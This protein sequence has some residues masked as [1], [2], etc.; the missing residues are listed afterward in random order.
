MAID[1]KETTERKADRLG[2]LGFTR[3]P[4]EEDPRRDPQLLAAIAKVAPGTGLREAIDDVI[5]SHEGALIVV[6]D[7]SGLAFLYSGGIR[8]DAPFRP[9][10]LYELAKMDGAIIVDEAI[11]RLA[12]ANVQLMP[13]PTIPSNE[14]GTRHRTAERVAKQ[15]GALVVSAS[16]QRE[17]VTVFVGPAR[18]QLDPV[19][20]VLAKT[21]Q[22]LGTLETYRQRL[23]QVLTRLTALEFQNAV[24]LDDVLVVLQRAEM[25][26][27]MARRI[28]RDCVELGTE[29][30]LIRLQLEELVGDVPGE[31]DAVVR[32]YH[33]LGAGDEATLALEELAGV[34]YQELLEFGRLAEVLGYDRGINPLD[35][36]VVPRGYRVL[37]HL[38]RLPEP[39]VRRVVGN[40]GSLD[41]V[42]RASQ[43]ELE[44]V[45]GVGSVRAREIREGLRRLQEHNLVDR[46]LQL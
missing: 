19:A 44:S 5:R 7:P 10:L 3:I 23:E 41:A 1:P 20:D 25:I 12:W 36:P 33:V 42:V 13:D 17:T 27:R 16:Q 37:S 14:T 6:G 15:T 18:Y 4:A 2:D 26:S 34:S 38:P 31:R 46:Y 9:Q 28:T 43:R 32:D 35:Q 40:L 39:L 30:R 29:G 45:D 11:K 21:N 22:A 8:L 24:V